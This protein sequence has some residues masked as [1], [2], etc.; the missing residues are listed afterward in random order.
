MEKIYIKPT[1]QE[2]IIKGASTEGHMDIFSYDPSG[3]QTKKLGHLF[4]IGHV[5]HETND[6]TYS[7]NLI[8]ALAKREYYSTF[9]IT[10][11]EAFAA[12]LKKI[13][14]VV[15]EFFEHK[16]L[17]INIGIF[18]I[19]GEQMYISKLGKFKVLL[20][21][22]NKTIDVL[23]NAMFDRQHVQE[24][25]F[26][27]I[28]S[29]QVNE[30]D[31][32]LAFYPCRATTARER[33]L[34]MYLHKYDSAGF[35][36]QLQAI[37]KEKDGFNCAMVYV[38]L[39]K[40]KETTT[41]P[42]TQPQ[43]LTI[44]QLATTTAGP[45]LTAVVSVTEAKTNAQKTRNSVKKP[46]D[47]TESP[48]IKEVSPAVSLIPEKEP[49]KDIITTP[50]H[51]L[52]TNIEVPQIIPSEF[53]RGKKDNFIS[54]AVHRFQLGHLT[55]K[56]K[57]VL[58]LI[59][60]ALV[61]GTSFAV[62]AVININPEVNTLN[63]T[64]KTA[65]ERLE[66]AKI[67]LSQNDKTGARGII[68][69]SIASLT[70]LA[71]DGTESVEIELRQLLDEIDQAQ[72]A[73]TSLV[74]QLPQDQGRA[75]LLSSGKNMFAY[76]RGTEDGVGH[77]LTIEN[78]SV[79]TSKEVVNTFPSALVTSTKGTPVLLDMA[80]QKTVAVK[81]SG[82]EIATFSIPQPTTY[83][84]YEDNLY[85]IHEGTIQK[86]ADIFQSNAVPKNWM[87]NG[88]SIIA[89]PALMAIDGSI[90]IISKDGI[91]ATYFRGEKVSEVATS[92]SIT[93]N[94]LLLTHNDALSLYLVDT[95]TGRI[96][97]LDKKTGTLLKTLKIGS[98]EPI[99]TATLATD[100]TIYFLTQDNKIWKISAQ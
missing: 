96:Y 7:I 89:D 22:D 8:S 33:Y 48:E 63:D 43:E 16:G 67:R 59:A 99:V 42:R 41:T 95:K 34:K 10:P 72:D 81:D 30:K 21:R 37:K 47:T 100:N 15:E 74:I 60:V 23:N 98:Q 49:V 75:I 19:A 45:R 92:L 90:F 53:L 44:P 31:R 54:S 32:I 84:F 83:Y 51:Y 5:Q 36:Q 56:K 79:Q 66:L 6:M 91:L 94:H 12:T 52:E 3:E 55:P 13:N 58:S 18:A 76:L 29:G 77:L 17:K 82:I 87:K 64:I 71:S 70:A 28:I 80:N 27:S 20:A 86:A 68:N 9:N 26:S 85:F 97:I 14:E 46:V 65:Q 4:L 62:R 50:N 35:T 1:S 39:D 11:K 25:Q 57:A 2:I 93:D 61:V 78:G 73:S 40:V 24:K 88:A 38:Q 69:S